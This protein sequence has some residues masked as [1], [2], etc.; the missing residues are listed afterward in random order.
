MWSWWRCGDGYD[1]GGGGDGGGCV[2]ILKYI[3]YRF[4]DLL[5][6]LLLWVVITANSYF[7]ASSDLQASQP[8]HIQSSS[9][10]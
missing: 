4:T 5:D 10:Q 8:R 9:F 6:G 7:S 2:Q 3:K 1:D